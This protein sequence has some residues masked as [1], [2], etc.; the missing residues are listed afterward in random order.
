MKFFR[1]SLI[2]VVYAGAYL[3]TI[4]QDADPLTKKTVLDGIK[5]S[6]QWFV[7]YFSENDNG[8]YS[9]DF[10][11][12]RGYI[13]ISKEFNKNFSARL[14]QDISVDNEGDG[15][16]DIELRIKYA[17][18]KYKFGDWFFFTN[19]A[20]EFGVVHR[21]WLSFE[22]KINRY[23]SQGKMFFER[24]G[25][26]S[27]ADYGLYF[28]SLLGGKVSDEYQKS[29]SKSFPGKFGSIG[30]G[31]FNGGGYNK[32][33]Y[34]TYK[35]VELR[36]TLRPLGDQMPELQLS[37]IGAFGKGNT[38]E[39]PDYMLNS[40][41]I[42]YESS[43]IIGTLTYYKGKGL[44]DGS[45]VNDFG[46]SVDQSGYSGFLELKINELNL[47]LIG[48]YDFFKQDYTP[49]KYE[50]E[51]KIVGIAYHFYKNSK[52]LLSYDDVKTTSLSERDKSILE[53]TL[54]LSF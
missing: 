50:Y 41:Y 53:F 8:E 20:V 6:G 48:R 46:N 10:A 52:I 45:A 49:V 36:A 11:I 15:I 54:E 42:S 1:F 24:V 21:P 12:K 22:Q 38:E 2:L 47:S 37:Y 40:G 19:P 44:Q 13:T 25:L 28:E 26:V 16:G 18:A 39:A 17:Y 31:V 14:T 51:G 33:E 23:R 9:N 7:G 29:V 3:S 43:R 4:G 32:L 5:I 30:I 34:N 27:S 35:N